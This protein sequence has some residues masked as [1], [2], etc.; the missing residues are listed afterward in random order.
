MVVDLGSNTGMLLGIFKQR[1]MNVLG[2]EPAR[3]I[4]KIARSKDI[5][6]IS[7]FF[8]AG[9][10]SRIARKK[11]RPKVITG[12]NVFAHADDLREFV[13]GVDILLDDD[14]VFVIEVPY[15]VDLIKNLE[16]DTIYHEHLSYFSTKP[17]VALFSQFGLRIVDVRRISIHGGSIRIFVQK[18]PPRRT[19]RRLA[20]LLK[21]ESDMGLCSPNSYAAFSQRVQQ[22]RIELCALLSKLTSQGKRIVGVSAPAKGNTLLNYCKIGPET[23]PYIVEKSSLKYHLYTP[24]THIPVLPESNLLKDKPDYALVLA[25][26]FANEIM[27]NLDIYKRGGGKFIVPVPVPEVI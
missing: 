13:K 9:V 25:W 4:A 3:N 8:S 6:T 12:T 20:S 26:N 22:H 11:G 14:G 23:L 10:A 18:G 16:Y 7:D 17:L 27:Q 21:L 5:D 15:L 1:G 19:S 24:G 2:V